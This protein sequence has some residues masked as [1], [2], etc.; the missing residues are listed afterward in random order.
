MKKFFGEAKE[1]VSYFLALVEF[2]RSHPLARAFLLWCVSR[3]IPNAGALVAK[4]P[5]RV[6]ATATMPTAEGLRLCREY[7]LEGPTGYLDLPLASVDKMW[8]GMGPDSWSATVR[9]AIDK[10]GS[11]VFLCSLPHDIWFTRPY[12]DGTR[13]TYKI[14]DGQ[15]TRNSDRLVA[16][17]NKNE[18]WWGRRWNEFSAQLIH[19]ALML[20][21]YSA[22]KSAFGRG[23]SIGE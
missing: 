6:R 22:W 11:C 18:N 4:M 10:V 20:G 8:N 19:D 2:S 5:Q 17:A 3:R 16:A 23:E 21:A 13:A 12:N 14:V 15:W 7:G 9:N 1:F